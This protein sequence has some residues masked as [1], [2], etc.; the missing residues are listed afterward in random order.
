MKL[1]ERDF[2]LQ[3]LDE[4]FVEPVCELNYE[5]A[6]QLT[7]AVILSAQCTDKR[8][9]IVTKT[10]FEQYPTVQSLAFANIE[11]VKETIKSL[12]FFNV[13]SKNI[14]AMAK[15]VCFKYGGEIPN[16]VE[17][18][19]TLAGIGRKTANVVTS[20]L[21]QNN[22]IATDT[23]VLRVSNRLGLV[24]TKS[25]NEC[26]NLLEKQFKKN[27]HKLHYQM[28]LFGRYF[29]TAKKPQCE[30]CKMQGICKFYKKNAK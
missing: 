1:S 16:N 23:H 12:G 5:N 11:E 14:I 17:D 19:M 22:V 26:T 18:L 28:V 6:Y 21:W 3:W 24:N 30:K 13:K 2:F 25:A 9:N 4:L 27:R 15:D 20:V 8:V 29:C 10:L 7:V